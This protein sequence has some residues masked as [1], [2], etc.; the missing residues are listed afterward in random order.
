MCTSMELL[1]GIDREQSGCQPAG[2]EPPASSRDAM[3]SSSLIVSQ[4]SK[5]KVEGFSLENFC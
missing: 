4:F 2:T 1:C 3:E 5:G